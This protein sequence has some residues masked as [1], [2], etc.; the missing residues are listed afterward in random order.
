MIRVSTMAACAMLCLA[1]ALST[2]AQAE[3]REVLGHGRLTNND[4]FGDLD[5]RWQT[6]SV[7]S[8][9]VVGRGWTGAP[10]AGDRPFAGALSL[11]VHTHFMRRGLE[12]TLGADIVATGDQ[13]GLG[14]LQT[15]IHD[16]LGVDPASK[17]VLDAQIENNVHARVVAEAGRTF[18]LGGQ[19]VVRPFAEARW[20]VENIARVGADF[21]LGSA[22]Q[23]EVMVR[24]TVTGQRYRTVSN[25]FT[26]FSYVFGG[27]IAYVESS[28]Y[29]PENRVDLTETRSRVR[30][31]LHWQGETNAAFYGVTW[32]SEEFDAQDTGQV[33]GSVRLDFRF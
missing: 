10:A 18:A 14:A 32:L 15:A 29:L 5:D 12:Y 1:P 13:T 27:D 20:G 30:A 21:T 22:G 11:G 19:A 8:S 28:E 16:G 24:D 33:V 17:A 25:P 9:R 23:G 4:L 2:P 31:G 26:G 6:G 7:S 3:G